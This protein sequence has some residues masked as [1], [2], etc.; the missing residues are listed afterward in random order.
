MLTECLTI[1]LRQV[2][3][4][5]DPTLSTLK[6]EDMLV[7]TGKCYTSLVDM[8]GVCIMTEVL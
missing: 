5:K 7:H 4:V 8:K 6:Y 2:V 3:L 1:T